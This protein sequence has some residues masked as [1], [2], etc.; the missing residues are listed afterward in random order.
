MKKTFIRAA[1][2]ALAQ[3]F[4]LYATAQLADNFS[5]GDFS[6]N[7]AWGGNTADWIVNSALRLQSNNTVANSSF[8]LSTPST[9]ATGTQWELYVQLAFNPSSANYVDMDSGFCFLNIGFSFLIC[10]FV[11]LA[12]TNDVIEF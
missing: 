3:L 4:A 12:I 1:G 9:V 8:Y 10:C 2:I 6:S 5:D 11:G 7:P